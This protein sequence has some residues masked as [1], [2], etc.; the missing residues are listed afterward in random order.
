MLKLK[1]SISNNSNNP[2][3]GNRGKNLKGYLEQQSHFNTF[4]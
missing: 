4:G 3:E 2:S 1:E